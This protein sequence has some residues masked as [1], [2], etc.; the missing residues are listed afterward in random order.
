[1]RCA[2][3]EVAAASPQIATATLLRWPGIPTFQLLA[4]SNSTGPRNE[5]RKCTACIV[6]TNPKNDRDS[7]RT[8]RPFPSSASANEN[9]TGTNGLCGAC[10]DTICMYNIV[11]G[12]CDNNG[13]GRERAVIAPDAAAVQTPSISSRLCSPSNPPGPRHQKAHRLMA[14]RRREPPKRRRRSNTE[15]PTPMPMPCAN[16]PTST[17]MSP[18]RPPKAHR[19]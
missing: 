5:V 2:S 16:D 8:G 3:A 7:C 9:A 18:L 11:L 12:H 1:M 17:A 15:R 10:R 19:W 6:G 14:A 13:F 4:S